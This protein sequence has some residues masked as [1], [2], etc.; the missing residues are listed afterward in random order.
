MNYN[1][2]VEHYFFQPEHVGQLDSNQARVFHSRTGSASQGDYFDLYLCCDEDGVILQACFKAY[3]N[4]YLIAGVEWACR[5]LV[6]KHIDEHSGIDYNLLI[7]LFDIPRSYYPVA[8]LVEKGY[9]DVVK[10][11]KDGM[12]DMSKKR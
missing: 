1:E 3:G 2:L 12:A 10:K 4:P 8:L 6:G 9:S 5:Q 11:L 7:Q